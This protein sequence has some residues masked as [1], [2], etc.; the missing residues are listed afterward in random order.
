M[1]QR[2]LA[3]VLVPTKAVREAEHN[4]KRVR[5]A[6]SAPSNVN[7][8]PATTTYNI[9]TPNVAPTTAPAV[10][11]EKYTA[12]LPHTLPYGLPTSSL[13]P[14]TIDQQHPPTS[15]FPNTLLEGWG[16][17]RLGNAPSDGCA[18]LAR[19]YQTTT[20]KHPS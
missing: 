14:W 16:V 4:G 3:R 6:P 17:L 13:E 11:T 9:P 15:L 5:F 8:A 1:T 10:E 20:M 2:R 7:S 12:Q 18:T 19:Y